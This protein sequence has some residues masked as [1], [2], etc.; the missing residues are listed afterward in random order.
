MSFALEVGIEVAQVGSGDEWWTWASKSRKPSQWLEQLVD[1]GRID[2][3]PELKALIG[4]PQ[5]PAWHPEGDVWTHTKLVCDAAAEIADREGLE[6]EDRAGLVLA[7]LCHDLGKPATTRMLDGNWVS[8]GHCEAGAPLA[9]SFL[10]RI[11]SGGWLIEVI[12]PLVREHLVHIGGNL[13]PR[14]VR[15]LSNR[16]G[17]ASIRQLLLLIEAD[18]GGR[19]PLP[20]GLPGS[21][22]RIGEAAEVIER[23][24]TRPKPLVSGDRL[25]AKGLKP[26]PAFRQILDRCYQAQLDG[27]FADPGRAEAFLDRLLAQIG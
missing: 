11:G 20:K 16:L 25:I 8:R 10:E 19:P 3:Y 22:A 12:E 17:Q 14:M 21:A 18:I 5:N 13:S 4:V 7:A 2:D 6:G 1:T 26:G 9:R 15:R 27:E 23:R 24:G